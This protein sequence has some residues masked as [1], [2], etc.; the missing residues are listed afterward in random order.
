MDLKKRAAGEAIS[1]IKNNTTIGLGAGSTIAYMI[2][3]LAEEV[4][5]G[6]ALKVLT[7]SF[8]THQLLLQNGFFVQPITDIAEMDIYFDGCDQLDKDL[9]A[10]KSGGGIHTREKLLA[11]MAKQFILVGDEAKYVEQFDTRFPLVVELLP[12][13][14]SYVSINIQKLYPGVK[15][16]IRMSNK[17][18]GAVITDNCNYL[19]DIWFASWPD[20]AQ[21]NRK[22]KEIT[23][24]VETSLF[25]KLADKAII[26]GE[27]GIK[28]LEKNRD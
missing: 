23:G 8:T 9:N 1:F 18:D 20:L 10:L 19:L 17:K 15:S 7:S 3:L 21:L 24:V 27:N 28:I 4:R 5:K 12:E 6:L 2:E 22:I 11:S 13:A 25:Y 14:F 16:V 26:A